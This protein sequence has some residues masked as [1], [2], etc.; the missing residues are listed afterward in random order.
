MMTRGKPRAELLKIAR[1][2]APFG[3]CDGFVPFAKT[4]RSRY[5]ASCCAVQGCLNF[6]RL[7]ASL[8]RQLYGGIATLSARKASAVANCNFLQICSTVCVPII[9]R[10]VTRIK[11]SEHKGF[12]YSKMRESGRKLQGLTFGTSFAHLRA[13]RTRPV[14]RTLV[15]LVPQM[16]ISLRGRRDWKVAE[17]MLA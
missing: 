2:G 9:L 6:Q 16:G 12:H 17:S 15:G 3:V 4:S 11:I 8:S 1:T 14:T 5:A 10:F 13:F 7:T